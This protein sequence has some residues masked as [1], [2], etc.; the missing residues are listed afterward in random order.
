MSRTFRSQNRPPVNREMEISVA[1]GVMWFT[2]DGKD[3]D[4]QSY[5]ELDVSAVEFYS[6]GD[7]KGDT[8]T[9]QT[10]DVAPLMLLFAADDSDVQ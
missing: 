10:I 6:N 3:V 2:Y 1:P 5:L 9:E 7:P 4:P 8:P